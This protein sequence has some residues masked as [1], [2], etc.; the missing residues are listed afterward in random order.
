MKKPSPAIFNLAVQKFGLNPATTLFV[1][2]REKNTSVARQL[3]F[4]T[5]LFTTAEA[6]RETIKRVRLI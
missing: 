1:D 4:Q 6:L 3:G 2:D 5:E